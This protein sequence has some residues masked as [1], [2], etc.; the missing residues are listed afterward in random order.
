MLPPQWRGQPDGKI[1]RSA[2]RRFAQANLVIE[3]DEILPFWPCLLRVM[4]GYAAREFF[5]PII[6]IR[7]DESG[8]VVACC[9]SISGWSSWARPA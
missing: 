6:S 5:R 9:H 2:G 3:F 8:M 4:G 7:L 1:Q